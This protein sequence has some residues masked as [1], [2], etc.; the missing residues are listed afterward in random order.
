MWRCHS[1]KSLHKRFQDSDR[2]R[3]FS[4]ARTIEPFR[5]SLSN[6]SLE[7]PS[8]TLFCHYR[9]LQGVQIICMLL[10][11]SARKYQAILSRSFCPYCFWQ[12]LGFRVS[13]WHFEFELKLVRLFVMRSATTVKFVMPSSNSDRC[14]VPLPLPSRILYSSVPVRL[15]HR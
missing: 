2:T 15:R 12:G 1:N 3:I 9:S 10:P 14:V 8:T 5:D 11:T 7:R 13:Q 4:N 6:S